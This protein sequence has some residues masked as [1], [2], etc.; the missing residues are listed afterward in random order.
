MYGNNEIAVNLYSK[1]NFEKVAV[2]KKYYNNIDDAYLMVKKVL[3][4]E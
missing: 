4:N 3:V 2:R 1:F